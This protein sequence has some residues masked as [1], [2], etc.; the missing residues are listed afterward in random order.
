M[1][2][3]FVKEM[4]GKLIEAREEILKKFISENEDF[5]RIV[6]GLEAKDYADIAA[7]DIA[8]SKMEAINRH[9][10]NRLKQ[11][12]SAVSRIHNQRYGLCLQC[13]KKIPEDRLRAIPYAVLCI[14]CKNKDE[15]TR[16]RQRA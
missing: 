11:I 15:K 3:A 8:T 6:N 4:E 2:K 10:S 14:E 12:D 7:D 1:D 5:R 16:K 9:D 13:G